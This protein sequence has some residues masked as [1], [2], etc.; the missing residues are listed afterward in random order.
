[1]SE[2]AV[3]T[4]TASIEEEMELSLA[5]SKGALVVA[6]ENKSPKD[7]ERVK[8]L[9]A[10][11]KMD[12]T[13]SIISFGTDA[14]SGLAQQTDAMLKGVRNKDTGP[15]G[16]VMNGLMV[17]IRG[18]GLDSLDPNEKPNFIKRMLSKLTPL[19]K[20]IQSYES[21]EDQVDAMV[22]KLREHQ[23]TLRRD[24]VMLDGMYDEALKFFDEL[25]FYIE[26]GELK[27][28]DV[29]ANDIPAKQ[30]ELEAA[31]QGNDSMRIANE[32]RD[33]NERTL[34]LE[35]KVNDLMLTRTATMQMLPQLRMIQ[36]VDKGLVTKIESAVQV[37]IPLWKGQIAMAI[38]I[39]NAA[40]A[41]KT[42]RMVGDAT[43]E[44][45]KANA[46]LLR[47]ASG[48][49]RTEMERGVVDIEALKFVNSELIATIQ[50]AGDIAEAGAKARIAG[51]AEM[52][53]LETDLKEALKAAGDKALRVTADT[54]A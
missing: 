12:V 50:E 48:E 43:S 42:T 3:A 41:A 31:A 45:L 20:F 24:V 21:I 23:S 9:M 19:Q 8:A 44:M 25:A 49:A 38:T 13:D 15:V 10:L 29:K 6:S 37:T 18:L 40:G 22:S 32:L 7:Q 28:A 52:A 16:E 11:I 46:T 39:W 33:L 2:T 1:M 4:E 26:A 35:R 14:Q 51:Q 36:D 27:L 34:D 17:E 47:T 54:A 30:A 53:K 5:E